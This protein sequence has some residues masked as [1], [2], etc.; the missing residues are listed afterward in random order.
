MSPQPEQSRAARR[1]RPRSMPPLNAATQ[2]EARQLP[3]AAGT[4]TTA[5]ADSGQ[6]RSLAQLRLGA[7]V[8][9]QRG[10]T[11]RQAVQQRGPARLQLGHTSQ[12]G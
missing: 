2:P 6:P 12:G 5:S 7:G 11:Q 10:G 4:A 3:C 1:S 8:A 9:G